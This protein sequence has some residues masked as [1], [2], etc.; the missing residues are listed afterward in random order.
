MSE[1]AAPSPVPVK[2]G[3]AA[4]SAWSIA[5]NVVQQGLAFVIFAVLARW[6]TPH[7]FGLLAIAHLLVL[8]ARMSLL[9]AVAMP[10]VRAPEV[11]DRLFDGLFTTC[12]SVSAVV[13]CTMA[14]FSWPMAR[15]F[16]APDLAPVLM[17][18]G[19]SVLLFGLARAHEARLLREANFRLTAIRSL[20]SVSAGG[21]AALWLASRG[22]GAMALVVQQLVMGT[23][24][25]L[26]AV[27]AEWRTWRPRWHWSTEMVR[28]HGAEMRRVGLGAWVSYAN[29]NGDAALVS[30]LFGPYATGLYNLAKRVLSAAYLV[31]AASLSRVGVSLFVQRQKDPV[32]LA[33]SYTR[34]LGW[35][36]LLLVPLYTMA[37]LV[38]EPLVVKVFGEKWRASAPLFGWMSVAYVCQSAFWL[39]QNLSLATKHSRRALR[40]SSFQLVLSALLALALSP[41]GMQGV[42]AGVALGSLAGCCVVQVAVHRQLGLRAGDFLQAALPALLGM[43][44]SAAALHGLP[45]TG[46]DAERWLGLALAVTLGLLSYAACASLAHWLMRRRV[47]A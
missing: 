31:V 35:T 26:I 42:A 14:L 38:A 30:V 20:C 44:A 37:T 12:T 22:F 4:R 17:G 6:L 29:S 5:D 43:A 18:M 13:A 2:G 1:R 33:Q 41:F 15:F 24:A 39:G 40:I 19:L 27:V 3:W 28:E 46:V 21:A 25:L 8:F 36:L 32:A 9:D 16:G 47:G 7:E 45:Y 23:V 11:N 34:M 10:V